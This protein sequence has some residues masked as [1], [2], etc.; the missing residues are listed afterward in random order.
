[1]LVIGNRWVL[2]RFP[3]YGRRPTK[4]ILG[5]RILTEADIEKL[6]VDDLKKLAAA[7]REFCAAANA[8]KA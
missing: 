7:R 5:D 8:K 6:H 4:T 2:S 1:M 3:I